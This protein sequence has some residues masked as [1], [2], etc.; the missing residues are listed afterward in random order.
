MSAEYEIARVASGVDGMDVVLGGGLPQRRLTLV[1]GTAGSGKTLAAVQFLASGI[2]QRGEPGV[3][4]TFEER[5]GAIRRNFRSFGWDVAAWEEAGQW[6]F[7]DASP[8]VEDDTVIAG[9]YDLASLVVRVKH[10]VAESGARRVALDSTGSLVDQFANA[11]AARRA[12]FQVAAELQEMGVTALMTAERGEDY[13][14]IT[15]HGFE[16]FVADNVVVL[17]NTLEVE[18]R[19]RT[20]E[21]LKLRGGAHLKGEQLFTIRTGRGMV[22]IPQETVSLDYDPSGKRLSS[23]LPELDAMAGGGYFDKSL[24][25]VTGAAGTGKSLLST[26]FIAGGASNGERTLLHSFEESRGQ[27]LRNAARWGLD[28]GAMEE[29]GT[30]R[31]VA[32]LPESASLEDHL[33]AMKSEIA[34]FKP[35]RVAIDSLT[36]LQRVATAKTFREY[37][38]GLSF[39]IKEHAMIGMVTAATEDVGGGPV[40]GELH[41]STVCDAIVVLQYIARGAEVAR[42]IAVLKM[43]GSDHAKALREYTVDDHGMH[44]GEPLAVRGWSRLPEVL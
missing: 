24:V 20:V 30:L 4:V 34:E 5:P 42:A 27:L 10:A 40:T 19:R 36:A 21:V 18:K 23:G 33:L 41:L 3:F 11:V 32:T 8:H 25:L 38:L 2:E 28:L 35:D 12:L 17:R 15:R 6:S 29:D 1:T 44:I 43:R 13:G 39:H 22:V 16:E 31:V 7:V 26:H 37:L 14:P 9:D